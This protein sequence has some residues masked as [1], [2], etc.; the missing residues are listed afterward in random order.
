MSTAV[1]GC[2]VPVAC[3]GPAERPSPDASGSGKSRFR[4]L[5]RLQTRSESYVH[6]CRL[7]QRSYTPPPPP[8]GARR[9]PSPGA[10]GSSIFRSAHCSCFHRQPKSEP[11][12]RCPQN[13]STFHAACVGFEV[14]ARRSGTFAYSIKLLLQCIGDGHA[15]RAPVAAAAGG[16][17][18]WVG[19][20][21]EV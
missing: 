16:K 3:R 19:A 6:A 11:L 10:Y 12:C 13:A 20:G 7:E 15:R 9:A 2:S 4:S 8:P 18:V 14:H 1:S 17:P 21:H 5:P